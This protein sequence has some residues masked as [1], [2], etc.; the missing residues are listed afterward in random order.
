MGFTD[1]NYDTMMVN[2][3]MLPRDAGCSPVSELVV[4]YK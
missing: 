3:N 1:Y 2:E 4:D